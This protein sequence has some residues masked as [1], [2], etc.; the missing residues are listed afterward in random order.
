MRSPTTRTGHSRLLEPLETRRLLATFTVNSLGDVS[1]P[2]SNLTLRE[3]VVAANAAAGTDTIA[4]SPTL[5]STPQ[6]I[7]LTQGAIP[8]SQSL[9]I[10]NSAGGVTVDGNGASRHF[11]H[12]AGTLAIGGLTLQNGFV[13]ITGLPG[14]EA[15]DSGGS[16]L[17]SA[18]TNLTLT[19][20]NLLGNEGGD[21][22]AVFTSGNVTLTDVTA[23]GNVS[24][25]PDSASSGGAI[26]AFGG[27]GTTVTVNGG[28]FRGN[29][30]LV[31]PVATG[32]GGAIR[33]QA[34][35]VS[36][37]G[38]DF[39]LNNGQDGPGGALYFATPNVT[40]ANSTFTSNGA[41][42]G[43]TVGGPI[44][45][46][47]I[48]A[49]DVLNNVTPYNLTVTG[50]TFD[51][52][53]ST[54]TGG[55]IT[56]YGPNTN[57]SG[58]TFTNNTAEFQQDSADQNFVTGRGGAL[59]VIP[60]FGEALGLS[61]SIIDS[62][63]DG[64][65]SQGNGGAVTFQG[66]LPPPAA[67]GGVVADTSVVGG[68]EV[69]REGIDLSNI[70]SAA[71]LS[72]SIESANT[73]VSGDAGVSRFGRA[74]DTSVPAL[75]MT[76]VVMSNNEAFSSGG[77]MLYT[78]PQIVDASQGEN[79]VMDSVSFLDNTAQNFAGGVLLSNGTIL[80][81]NVRVA[82]NVVTGLTQQDVDDNG[83]PV[84][85]DNGDPV[86]VTSR[87]VVG[88]LDVND[89]N[90]TLI[91]SEIAENA[92]L[93]G[94]LEGVFGT[95]GG[96]R[97]LAT[98]PGPTFFD[99]GI[100]LELNIVQSTISNNTADFFGGMAVIGAGQA[101]QAGE[102]TFAVEITQSTI[103]ENFARLDEN[104]TINSSN[105]QAGNSVV[106]ENT[107]ISDNTSFEFDVDGNAF[108]DD[109]GDP[110]LFPDNLSVVESEEFDTIADPNASDN[111]ADGDL[112]LVITNSLIGTGSFFQADVVT[113]VN[114]D[115]AVERR[116]LNPS[117]PT[118]SI[119]SDN[120][121]L[122][123][124]AFNGGET[125][126]HLPQ[127]GSPLI[128][129]GSNAIANSEGL[130][131][132][133]R[134]NPFERLFSDPD[135]APQI[136]DIG[137][138]ERT[139]APPVVTAQAFDANALAVSFTFDQNVGASLQGSD[140]VILNTTTN[141]VIPSGPVTVNYNPA[142]NTATF[143]LVP[144]IQ[145]GTLTNGNYTF[146]LVAGGVTNDGGVAL[147]ADG[148]VMDYFLAGDANRD[149]AVSILDFAILRG[150]FG[151]TGVGFT[152][153]DFNLDGSVS[154]LD[155]AILRGNF[156]QSVAAPSSIFAEDELN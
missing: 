118:N 115:K 143:S 17:S 35:T 108:L 7:T 18:G 130:V 52:N 79:L 126:N 148:V 58:S 25:D 139:V 68:E 57:I 99:P 71:K 94:D 146:T 59:D 9:T 113:D 28:L 85:D 36:I 23:I 93:A 29:S 89:A 136:V 13:P 19:G 56:S 150:N 124:L 105:G 82:G 50:S 69:Q 78:G 72:Q 5:F 21:G 129:A 132:D 10:N 40:I 62:T 107:V 34:G 32:T 46:G 98:E 110:I 133:Q 151:Q 64:N 26:A 155:F 15:R 91:D 101:Q 1:A 76:D 53:T 80:G 48:Y 65:T 14:A 90:L 121:M 27:A 42:A 83:D 87:G 43:A 96:F 44:Y 138:I 111:L 92:S 38:T 47:A 12:T 128:D 51:G 75:T 95:I 147:E 145:N 144:L 33:A 114:G 70:S 104:V 45:G 8:V 134:G 125:R 60:R 73:R 140:L 116:P 149:R 11:T 88:G 106:I 55:A 123:E 31:T 66:L 131:F 84:F 156:G 41:S 117:L 77:A 112:T 135:T 16:I 63:F 22:G 153:A 86:L 127:A 154:I 120:P 54:D 2:D 152:G 49:T 122:G 142:T 74:L 37:D 97:F 141:T 61:H 109:N 103:V 119:I 67:R 137:S 81:T 20:T 6:T 100:T 30:A 102:G 39:E 3:A 24:F 4:F